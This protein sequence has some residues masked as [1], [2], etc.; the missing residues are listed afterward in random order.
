MFGLL[1]AW[2][3]GKFCLFCWDSTNQRTGTEEKKKLGPLLSDADWHETILE[4]GF[5]GA[6]ICVPDSHDA[7]SRSAIISTKLNEEELIQ[8]TQRAVIITSKNFP[9]HLRVIFLP[10]GRLSGLRGCKRGL[11]ESKCLQIQR[12]S[13][14]E[15]ELQSTGISSCEVL[16][17]QDINSNDL[18]DS[19]CIF[20]LELNATFLADMSDHDFASLKTMIASVHGI[21]WVT[22][23]CSE[24]PQKP[25]SGLV[26]VFARS[27]RSEYWAL[28][29]FELAL[30]M[31]SSI[32]M[33]V[34]R[35]IKV[36]QEAFSDQEQYEPE[37]RSRDGQLCISR[38]VEAQYSDKTIDA[39]IKK[40]QAKMQRVRQSRALEL[41]IG[42]PGL[43][44]TLQFK[45]DDLFDK[46]LAAEE[47]KQRSTQQV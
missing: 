44:E 12:A 35:I 2:R 5:S 10:R 14:I 8:K 11:L 33:K 32:S 36:Y 47:V 22:E 15:I 18:K 42:S 30:E 46:P 3:L 24:L 31:E 25:E 26:T 1:P 39:K 16:S 9:R 28:S 21:L 40:Q 13:Q 23:R 4:N 34:D 41:S 19:L 17:L 27:I 38:V 6:E 43:L 7:R 45:G 37:Y 29:F 20:L